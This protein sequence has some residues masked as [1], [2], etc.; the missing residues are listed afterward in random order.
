MQQKGKS[1]EF[2]SYFFIL[3]EGERCQNGYILIMFSEHGNYVYGYL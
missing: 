1:A 3:V 2:Q